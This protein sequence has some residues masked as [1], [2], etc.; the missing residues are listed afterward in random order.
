MGDTVQVLENNPNRIA[1]IFT[2]GSGPSTLNITPP[3]TAS[4][5]MYIYFT[6]GNIILDYRN[7]GAMVGY[8]WYAY[9]S[10]MMGDVEVSVIQSSYRPQR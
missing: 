4:D 8:S 6:G 10:A 5:G 7:H 1:V 2:A 9:N 3:T